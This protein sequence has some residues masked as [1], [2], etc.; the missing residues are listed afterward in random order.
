L[1]QNGNQIKDIRH[2][3]N[4]AFLWYL[5]GNYQGSVRVFSLNQFMAKTAPRYQEAKND[6]SLFRKVASAPACHG[7]FDH[8]MMPKR[9]VWRRNV[10]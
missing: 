3:K 8:D 10:Q 7:N 9:S 1:N 4:C 5:S 6:H 2:T